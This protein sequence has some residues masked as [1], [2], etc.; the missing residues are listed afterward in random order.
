[1]LGLTGEKE[2]RGSYEEVL[3]RKMEKKRLTEI[4]YKN[5]KRR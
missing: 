2:S 3:R 5:K 4:T 1:M